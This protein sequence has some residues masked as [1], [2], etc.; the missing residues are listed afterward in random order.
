MISIWFFW[1]NL[2]RFLIFLVN[3]DFKLV[4]EFVIQFVFWEF[5]EFWEFCT[6]WKITF[7]SSFMSPTNSLNSFSKYFELFSYYS[8]Y[9]NSDSSWIV[10]FVLPKYFVSV[11]SN[12]SL[13]WD[14]SDSSL[15]FL[16]SYLK[17]TKSSKSL[18]KTSLFINFFKTLFSL[19]LH[20][21]EKSFK[22]Y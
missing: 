11:F 2:N 13:N 14:S 15:K 4:N 1:L 16:N 7:V 20:L 9:N 8:K 3:Y 5:W 22:Y 6:F 18:L 12:Y 10:C 21:S 17:L 19:I